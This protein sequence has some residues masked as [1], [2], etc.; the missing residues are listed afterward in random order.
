MDR[1]AIKAHYISCEP[2]RHWFDQY[3]RFVLLS[4]FYR[5]P[6]LF[7]DKPFLLV[8][9]IVTSSVWPRLAV[10]KL[11]PSS[12]PC[13]SGSQPCPRLTGPVYHCCSPESLTS[14]VVTLRVCDIYVTK[15]PWCMIFCRIEESD[16]G[17][18]AIILAPTRELAQQ[19]E[20]ETLKFGKPLG[21]RTVAVIGGIS[22]EDQGFRLRMGCEV[23]LFITQCIWIQ[24]AVP[25]QVTMSFWYASDTSL[26]KIGLPS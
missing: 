23:S 7:R 1:P 6:P 3:L 13:W 16:Q 17:P 10:V 12:F 26:C 4:N 22:R 15:M 24:W 21:I 5:S 20:E 9:R 18:Y 8:Y 2:L 25:V 11:L 19:I 14:Y